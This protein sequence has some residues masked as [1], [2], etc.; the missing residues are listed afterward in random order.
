MNTQHIIIFDGVCNFCNKSVNFIIK[1]D[2]KNIFLFTPMQSKIAQDLILKYQIKNFDYDTILLIKNDKY[3][4]KTDAVLEILHDLSGLWI[5]FR[6]F[7][8]LP[9]SMRDYGY[10]LIA[11]N[12]YRLFG[13]A[14]SCMVPTRELKNK[15]LK[16]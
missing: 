6:V 2:K 1:R 15:F 9:K 11:K 8:V 14:D 4:S 16:Q 13:K 7:K 10:D 3:Y 12:R 5:V